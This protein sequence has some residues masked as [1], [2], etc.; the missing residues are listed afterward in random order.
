MI[1][2]Y[3]YLLLSRL[4]LYYFFSQ[5]ILCFEVQWFHLNLKSGIKY[6]F[7]LIFI[8]LTVSL[9]IIHLFSDCK[10]SIKVANTSDPRVDIRPLWLCHDEKDKSSRLTKIYSKERH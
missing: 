1:C 3:L 4:F 5:I 10:D 2:D 9:V 8:V 6:H 7:L